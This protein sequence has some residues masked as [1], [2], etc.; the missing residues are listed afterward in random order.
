MN[1][2]GREIPLRW[3]LS[4]VEDLQPQGIT[5]ITFTQE[6][7]SMHVDCAKFGIAEWCRCEDHTS[8]KSE[9][10]KYCRIKEPCYIDAGLEIPEEEYPCGKIIKKYVT[11]KN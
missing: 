11:N 6:M 8:T 10:C 3:K 7:A 9:V 2:K 1:D 4:K 5:K